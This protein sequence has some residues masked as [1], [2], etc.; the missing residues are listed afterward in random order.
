MRRKK[1]QKFQRWSKRERGVV[2]VDSFPFSGE[3]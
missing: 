2:E 3:E 1:R